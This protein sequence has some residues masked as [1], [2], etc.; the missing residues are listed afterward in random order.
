[1]GLDDDAHLGGHY[2]LAASLGGRPMLQDAIPKRETAPAG[3]TGAAVAKTYDSGSGG[4]GG[5]LANPRIGLSTLSKSKIK[6]SRHRWA[7][8]PAGKLRVLLA[9]D[10]IATAHLDPGDPRRRPTL[11]RLAFLDQT[12]AEKDSVS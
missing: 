11:P 9:A 2:L 12:I 1:V 10:A 5:R 6:P 7:K 8:T 4:K 3:N